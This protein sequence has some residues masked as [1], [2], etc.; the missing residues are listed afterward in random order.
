GQGHLPLE[1]EGEGR[2]L[3]VDGAEGD[4]SLEAV[5]VTH[6]ETPYWHYGG[7]SCVF[8]LIRPAESLSWARI[9]PGWRF[10][11]LCNLP[12]LAHQ[13]TSAREFCEWVFRRDYLPVT[14]RLLGPTP[15]APPCTSTTT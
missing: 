11:I 7:S 13:L 14:M 6:G 15:G 1:F 9:T 3:A 5:G 8:S 4:G 10:P 12:L 2:T